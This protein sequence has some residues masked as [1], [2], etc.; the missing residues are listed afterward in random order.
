MNNYFTNGYFFI[1]L[2]NE[3]KI[4]NGTFPNNLIELVPNFIE[5]GEFDFREDGLHYEFFDKDKMNHKYNTDYYHFDY[6][7][8]K[9][10]IPNFNSPL[11]RYNEQKKRFISDF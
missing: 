7:N 1:E 9:L 6:F 10:K 3:Y 11:Y 4:K 2:I 8:L 5:K